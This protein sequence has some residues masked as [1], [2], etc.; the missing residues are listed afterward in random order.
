MPDIKAS[1][2]G[3]FQRAA[4]NYRT[5]TVHAAGEDLDMIRQLVSAYSP[6]LVLD[7]GC[8]AGHTAVTV[9]PYAESVI[10]FDLTPSMLTQVEVLA[11]E[12]SLD[13]VSVR[14]GDVE[15]MP[16]EDSY[17]DTIVT[18]YSAHHWPNLLTA[19]QE[20]ARVLKPGGRLIVSD[21]IAPEDAARDTF[22]QTIELLRDPS[23]VRD[24]SVHQWKALL[25]E[26][27]FKADVVKLW[28]VPLH[29]DEWVTRINTP[30]L[31]IE[32]LRSLF[33]GASSEIRS[34][35]QLRE[36]HDFTIYGALFQG[37]KPGSGG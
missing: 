35:M 30:A 21:V 2:Q 32:M 34:A 10:A 3:Q 19:L 1:V 15:A 13:N 24:H 22:L 4:E 20:C 18:R 37:V 33:D 11:K 6:K 12:K 31:N 26:A 17:F 8:G 9:A 25:A 27:G 36:Q 16:F 7:A 14:Q 23:H 29:F 5:S 28:Q